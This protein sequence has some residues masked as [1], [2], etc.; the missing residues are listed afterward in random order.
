MSETIPNPLVEGSSQNSPVDGLVGE[1]NPKQ[2]LDQHRKT[3]GVNADLIAENAKLHSDNKER[4]ETELRDQ[5]KFQE[6][7]ETRDK[8]LLETRSKLEETNKSIEWADKMRAFQDT[9]GHSKI[10]SA[11]YSLVPVDEI[12]Y[13]EDGR[14]DQESLL[15]VVNTFKTTHHRLI[16]DPRSD[17]PNHR[18]GSSTGKGLSKDEW[19]SG[20]LSSKEMMD[21]FKEVNFDT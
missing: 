16:D 3:K 14:V 7:L 12:K 15:S 5:N 1:T 20:K 9:I 17:L 8:E 18:P 21:R 19:R 6:L 2:L 10:D 4:N 11:Y 13:G